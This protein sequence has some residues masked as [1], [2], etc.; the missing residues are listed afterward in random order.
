[1]A[2]KPFMILSL[3]NCLHTA[4]NDE[5]YIISVVSLDAHSDEGY[6]PETTYIFSSY[7]KWLEENNLRWINI[8][9]YDPPNELF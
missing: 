3:I 1:M 5:S 9:I 7:I 6:P 8:S 2:F 4:S